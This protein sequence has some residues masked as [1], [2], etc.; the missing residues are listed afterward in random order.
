MRTTETAIV[1]CLLGGAVGDAIGLPCEGLSRS[2]Q[3]SLFGGIDGH[4]FFCNRGI[5]GDIA[6]ARV[7]RDNI[8]AQWL[9]AIWEWPRSVFWMERLGQRLA[10]VSNSQTPQPPLR[11]SWVGVLLRNLLFLPIVLMHGFRRILPP[12]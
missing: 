11:L 4:R 2:R 12:Y 10:Q 7:G 1:G 8:P 6:G 9:D 5:L 3:R